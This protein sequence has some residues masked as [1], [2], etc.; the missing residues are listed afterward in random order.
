MAFKTGTSNAGEAST[1]A[2][3]VYNY[4]QVEQHFLKL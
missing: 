4:E 1:L 2:F 3:L